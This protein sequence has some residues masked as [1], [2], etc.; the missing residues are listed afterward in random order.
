MG[1]AISPGIVSSIGRADTSRISMTSESTMIRQGLGNILALMDNGI[2]IFD[3]YLE[4][5]YNNISNVLNPDQE[6]SNMSE[7]IHFERLFSPKTY[8]I[9][10]VFRIYVVTELIADYSSI[11]VLQKIYSMTKRRF[12]EFSCSKFELILERMKSKQ[13]SGMVSQ[14]SLNDNGNLGTSEL[15]S[16]NQ[17]RDYSF[18]ENIDIHELFQILTFLFNLIRDD[19]ANGCNTFMF[20]KNYSDLNLFYKDISVKISLV[21]LESEPMLCITIVDLGERAML[22]NLDDKNKFKNKLIDSIS[23]ELKTPINFTFATIENFIDESKEW[24]EAFSE[25]ELIKSDDDENFIIPKNRILEFTENLLFHKQQSE[26]VILNLKHMMLFIQSIVDYSLTQTDN[27][28]VNAD[29][30]EIV[31][32]V[33]EVLKIYCEQTRS[34]NI[35]TK[36]EVVPSSSGPKVM[37]KTDRMRLDVILSTIIFNSIKYTRS[38]NIKII[39]ESLEPRVSELKITVR[40]TGV[41]MDTKQLEI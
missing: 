30:V 34:K 22:L 9:D 36:V 15:K 24:V 5:V 25:K 20:L 35:F 7:L 2:I 11:L 13:N 29:Q 12:P 32:T 23:H 10:N 19:I 27:F 40:D 39:I 18:I 8:S 3:V 4:G 21:S 28:T 16:S 14:R 37:W 38:G 31:S 33:K 41:G 6:N 1:N 17:F 26:S